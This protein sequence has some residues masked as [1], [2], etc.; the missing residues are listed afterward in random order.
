[1]PS[2]KIVATI[3]LE[4]FKKILVF[5]LWTSQGNL[6]TNRG[7]QVD[8]KK[9]RFDFESTQLIGPS[10]YAQEDE[11]QT[12]LVLRTVPLESTRGVDQ[13]SAPSTGAKRAG[14]PSIGKH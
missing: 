10:S 8:Q 12:P 5:K 1:M 3:L 6:Q 11:L 7:S 13:G 2:Y 4:N 14:D 9:A